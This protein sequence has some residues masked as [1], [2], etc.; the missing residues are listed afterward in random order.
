MTHDGM[1]FC[2]K[3]HQRPLSVSLFPPRED[4]VKHSHLQGKK[5]LTRHQPCWHL[6]LGTPSRQNSEEI[7][8]CC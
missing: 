4:T 8:F 6:D 3:I 5:V 2:E 7:N 1:S